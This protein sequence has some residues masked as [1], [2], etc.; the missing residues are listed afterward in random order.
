[1]STAIFTEINRI[2]NAKTSISTKMAEMGLTNTGLLDAMATNISGI[3]VHDVSSYT[4]LVEEEGEYNINIG[5]YKKFFTVPAL[6]GDVAAKD[7]EI[8]ELQGQL[9]DLNET[10]STIENQLKQI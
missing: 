1:M 4:D 5:Y 8:A 10:L 7:A 2:K 3:T 6:E 9:D